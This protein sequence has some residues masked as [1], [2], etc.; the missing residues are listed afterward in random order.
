MHKATLT[1]ILIIALLTTLSG[2]DKSNLD[3]IPLIV[4]PAKGNKTTFI[5]YVSGDGG[6]NN[7]SKSFVAQFVNKG[8]SVVAIDAKKYFW[9]GKTPDEFAA[10]ITRIA[11][12]YLHTWGK[13]NF[14]L[15]GY[16]F[17]ADVSAFIPT[18]INA[19]IKQKLFYTV[20]VSPA[21]TTDYE[22]RIWDMLGPNNIQRKYNVKEELKKITTPTLCIFGADEQSRL[23]EE[24]P[25][26]SV[27]TRKDLTGSHDFEDAYE[28]L[29]NT[30]IA[31]TGMN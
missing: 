3:D 26:N 28:T 5:L 22:I 14:L 13:S 15:L 24:L 21:M 29:A 17:G 8:Y 31:Q 7:F 10:T 4:S 11:K 16:S 2:Q 6:W 23:K 27:I 30:V 9:D 20:L 1:V 12:H 18:R 25:K 19:E